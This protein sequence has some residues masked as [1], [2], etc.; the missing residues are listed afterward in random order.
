MND[1]TGYKYYDYTQTSKAYS[2]SEIQQ[3]VDS[4]VDDPAWW[5]YFSNPPKYRV[6]E[7]SSSTKQQSSVINKSPSK[8]E[9]DAFKLSKSRSFLKRT[10]S[11]VRAAPTNQ[12]VGSLDRRY[13]YVNDLNRVDENKYV[14]EENNENAECVTGDELLHELEKISQ[15]QQEESTNAAYDDSGVSIDSSDTSSLLSSPASSTSDLSSFSSSSRVILIRD[16]DVNLL[17]KV[18]KKANQKEIKKQPD[19][20]SRIKSGIKFKPNRQVKW[21]TRLNNYLSR[22]C[23]TNDRVSIKKELRK[24]RYL[25]VNAFKTMECCPVST[26]TRRKFRRNQPMKNRQE[27]LYI[28]SDVFRNFM[29]EKRVDLDRSTRRKQTT[30]NKHVESGV[31]LLSNQ[32]CVK[33][34]LA[35]SNTL[36][37]VSF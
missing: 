29:N 7:S 37:L 9:F 8:C 16:K 15:R 26:T 4:L 1:E 34:R 32:P 17:I 22:L 28:I 33:I 12:S 18:V 25:T 10:S 36:F 21:S 19:N 3:L 23:A 6:D 31:H 14:I 13:C 35:S 24:F 5:D 11:F 20:H 2:P 27:L 30:V